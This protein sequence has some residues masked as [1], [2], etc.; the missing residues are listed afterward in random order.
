MSSDQKHRGKRFLRR[1]GVVATAMLLLAAIATIRWRLSWLSSKKE[2]GIV[3]ASG[4]IALTWED[5]R[6]RGGIL[7]NAEV[8]H[9]PGLWIERIFDD[10]SD[11]RY[12]WSQFALL[13]RSGVSF[14]HRYMSI[15][16]WMPLVLLGGTTVLI[17]RHDARSIPPGHC[18][19]C[20]YSLTGNVSGICPECGEP[21]KLDERAT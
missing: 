6:S 12:S 21:C 15:P 2:M 3:L 18:S 8:L 14:P 16:L 1:A 10:L 7:F 5:R 13:P 17:F 4:A 11:A 20:G 9:S 19:T